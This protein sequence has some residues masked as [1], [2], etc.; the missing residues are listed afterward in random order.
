[1]RCD[2]CNAI[3][4]KPVFNDKT[5]KFDPCPTCLGEIEDAVKPE[6]DEDSDWMLSW[7]DLEEED[8]ADW[9]V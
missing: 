8:Y 5:G 4:P 6:P 1:M 2:I 3:I 9:D 7:T